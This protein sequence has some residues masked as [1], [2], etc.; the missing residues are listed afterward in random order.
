M[1]K[2]GSKTVNTESTKNTQQNQS[3]NSWGFA[4]TG[5]SDQAKEYASQILGSANPW[6]SSGPTPDFLRVNQEGLRAGDVTRGDLDRSGQYLSYAGRDVNLDPLDV[7]RYYNPYASA[8]LDALNQKLGIG[9]AKLRTANNAVMGGVGGDRAGVS[10]ALNFEQDQMARG[11][12]GAQFYKDALQTAQ[13]QQGAKYA[14]DSANRGNY[15]NAANAYASRYGAGQQMAGAAAR[16]LQ[17][18]QMRRSTMFSDLLTRLS[19]ILGTQQS[20]YGG[21]ESSMTGNE[22]GTQKQVTTTQQDPLSAI[23]GLAMTFGPMLFGMPPMGGG[24]GKGSGAGSAAGLS[25]FAEG[26]GGGTGWATN[27]WSGGGIFG[28]KGMG[29]GQAWGN[30]KRGGRVSP[31]AIHKAGGGL[32]E[33]RWGFSG[34]ADDQVDR[35]NEFRSSVRPTLDDRWG[36]ADPADPA[37]AEAFRKRALNPTQGFGVPT[38]RSWR[39]ADPPAPSEPPPA[40]APPPPVRYVLGPAAAPPQPSAP[41]SAPAEGYDIDLPP[42]PKYAEYKRPE[43]NW[44]DF[45]FRMGLATLAARGQTDSNGVPLGSLSNIGKGGLTALEGEQKEREEARKAVESQNYNINMTDQALM[46]REGLKINRQNAMDS[47]DERRLSRENL[48]EHREAER[49]RLA[50]R[51]AEAARLRQ[52][53]HERKKAADDEQAR[54]NKAEE[55]RKAFIAQNRDEQ[56]RIGRAYSD[57]VIVYKAQVRADNWRKEKTALLNS[58]AIR[59]GSIDL[60]EGWQKVFDETKRAMMEAREQAIARMRKPAPVP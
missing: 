41:R 8:A 22:T 30:F 20:N 24:M 57:D 59:R 35:D 47:A 38:T 12:L 36:G 16:A 7:D 3:Q 46:R 39:V 29:G 44:A 21:G 42:V 4:Q 58:G 11:Q 52:A 48:A 23:T 2:G 5:G 25:G 37:T 43:R 9:Q 49:R 10:E 53:E 45:L 26:A 1:C 18:E 27:P 34:P 15:Y 56:L 31:W 51:D 28:N 6:A 14:A 33:D 19:P 50:E 54:H 17:D 13:Q 40:A 55:A 60:E 32:V